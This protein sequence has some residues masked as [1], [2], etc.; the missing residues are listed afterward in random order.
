MKRLTK[1]LCLLL[2]AAS[3]LCACGDSA[4]TPTT[5]TTQPTT[6]PTTT[7]TTPTDEDAGLDLYRDYPVLKEKFV[8]AT[9]SDGDLILAKDGVANAAIV[10]PQD[11]S[12]AKSA[13][14]DLASYLQKITGASFPLIHDG[15]ELPGSNLILVGPTAKTAELGVGPYT[16][17][18]HAEKI[19]VIRK[20][21]CL[22]LCGN[23]DET[24]KGTQNAVTYFL[25]EAGCGWFSDEELWQVVP[26]K[27][28]LAVKDVDLTFT[29]S[30]AGRELGNLPNTLIG[31][32][33]EGG[34]NHLTG[35]RIWIYIPKSTYAEHPEW[36]A[37]VDGARSDP[38]DL[39][40]SEWQYCYSNQ[41]FTAAYAQKVIEYFDGNPNVMSMTAAVNDG[42][43]DGWCECDNCAAL[44]NKADQALDFA[45][46]VAEIVCEKYPE[47]RISTLAY[48]DTFLPPSKVKAHPNVEVMF[49]IETS[50]LDDLM[51]DRQIHE[52]FNDINKIEYSQ[53]WLS[54][55]KQ[56]IEAADVKHKSI[57]GWFC[58]DDALYGWK[59]I[60]WIQGNVANRNIDV[61]QALGVDYVFYDGTY[62]Y[63]NMSMPLRWPLYYTFAKCMYFDNLT[64][65]EVL[66]DA[67]QKLYGAAADEM[68]LFYRLLADSAQ[69]CTSDSG[70]NWVPPPLLNV[71]YENYTQLRDAVKA[72]NA[73]LDQLTPEQKERVQNQLLG[74]AY[75]DLSI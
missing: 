22:I 16:G 9:P 61:F 25:E 53:S 44:G 11:N 12:K 8:T 68:F 26:E 67:C 21:N 50:P 2:V 71:Y 24:Y 65:E 30:I 15:E 59:N 57:W 29:P 49:C 70:I 60:P 35:Q 41:E 7:P 56:W 20:G 72:A 39:S 75:I 74:W 47:K 40:I 23:D 52:G 73:K 63:S 1:L 37:L 17:Y 58:I 18:P 3:V 66:Y 34:N 51:A 42:W 27:A 32:W 38:R 48:H 28:T 46:R 14:E 31:R 64:G 4:A 13:A 10:Y 45:N 55:V 33:Y 62:P 19:S 5:G 69:M 43:S 36:F 6:V 54:N